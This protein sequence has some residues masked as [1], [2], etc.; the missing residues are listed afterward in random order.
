MSDT[1]EDSVKDGV[2][3]GEFRDRNSYTLKQLKFLL[4][5]CL[6][7][8]R[9][10]NGEVEVHCFGDETITDVCV[11]Y[12]KYR[13]RWLSAYIRQWAGLSF[14]HFDCEVRLHNPG[15]KTKCGDTDMYSEALA[16]SLNAKTG[17]T[18]KVM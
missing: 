11:C 9:L 14:Y 4:E 8:A 10:V 6:R 16:K 5:D 18:W 15:C 13:N 12:F 17:K 2:I 1:N 3:I 7:D